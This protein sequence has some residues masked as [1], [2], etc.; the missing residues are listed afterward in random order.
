[1]LSLNG[2]NRK[3]YAI[4][5]VTNKFFGQEVPDYIKNLPSIK[6]DIKRWTCNILYFGVGFV[7]N[8]AVE[9]VL[10]K[11]PNMHKF[12][13][14]VAGMIVL[15]F[16]LMCSHTVSAKQTDKFVKFVDPYSSFAL[17][18]MNI[19]FVPAVVQIVNNPPT[20][21]AEVGR[22]ICVFIVGYFIG[23]MLSTLLVRF[24]R[25][26]I[27]WSAASHKFTENPTL[28]EKTKMH[29]NTTMD[30]EEVGHTIQLNPVSSVVTLPTVIHRLSDDNAP[31]CSSTLTGISAQGGTPNTVNNTYRCCTSNNNTLYEPYNH[32]QHQHGPLHTFAIWCM[33]QSSFDDLTFFLIFC[34]C[35]FVF[36]PLPEDN[37]AMPFFR[38]FLYFSM[39]ILIFSAACRL[40]VKMRLLF[41]P[42]IVTAA[43][44]MAGIA[45]FERVKGFDI[46]YGVDQFK[47]GVTFISLVE[48]TNVGWPGAGDILAAT[49]DVSIISMAFNVYKNRPDSI[50]HWVLI[51]CSVM[52]MTFLVMF[53]TPLFAYSIGCS[54][55]D[56]IVW[57][58][59]S[60]TTAIGIVIGDVLGANQSVVTCIIVFTGI[61]GPLCAPLLY[62]LAR[63]KDDDYMTIGITMG[64]SSHGVGTAYLISKNTRASGMSSLAFAIFGTTGV[65]IVSIPILADTIRHL[66]GY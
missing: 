3:A 33:Q 37:A 58:S 63:V 50:R 4:S 47:N 43:G 8:W 27:F 38:L 30:E 28:N 31:S 29:R 14:N 39:I 42:I 36:L 26:L 62:K 12:P 6:K 55:A 49:M 23:F 44:V 66:S 24:F 64:S 2:L 40:P 10:G 1:M 60:V 13:S 61:M 19:M 51:F 17:K 22:M 65:I 57:S 46:K 59:R 25:I 56:S 35:A 54:S 20:T 41:H 34:I 53:V 32:H 9:V 11:M 45:Y 21:A 48:R 15:F 5:N 7:Y 52:P 16:L 18:S